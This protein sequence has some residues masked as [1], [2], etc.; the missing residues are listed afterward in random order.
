MARQT[1][2]HSHHPGPPRFLQ[3]GERIAD[4]IFV[5]MAHGF[6]R[7]NL[8]PTI[9]GKPERNPENY[10]RDA[11][12]WRLS[13]RPPNSSATIRQHMMMGSGTITG[14]TTPLNLSLMSQAGISCSYMLLTVCMN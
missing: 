8:A 4:P 9:A 1:P 2:S 3:V 6:D 10:H 14:Y 12:S 11:F 7:D 5:D 13:A